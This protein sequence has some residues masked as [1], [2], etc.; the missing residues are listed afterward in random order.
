MMT[1]LREGSSSHLSVAR[2]GFV[3]GQ[4]PQRHWDPDNSHTIYHVM[5]LLHGGSGSRLG[6]AKSAEL[7]NTGMEI[8]TK[9]TGGRIILPRLIEITM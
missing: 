1:V 9:R 4:V 6:R 7:A 8:F 3:N 2:K 5:R